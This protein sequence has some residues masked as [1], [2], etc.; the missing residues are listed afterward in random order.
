MIAYIKKGL[1][2]FSYEIVRKLDHQPTFVSAPIGPIPNHPL[3]SLENIDC[4]SIKPLTKGL[5]QSCLGHVGPIYKTP[6][7][8]NL[9]LGFLDNR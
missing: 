1:L 7:I 3:P 5:A 4:F 6:K 8:N 9:R 2:R